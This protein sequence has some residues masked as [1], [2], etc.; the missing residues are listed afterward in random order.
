MVNLESTR[1][2]IMQ[3]EK[4]QKKFDAQLAEKHSLAEKNAADRDEA[5]AKARQAETKCLSLTRELDELHDSMEE[6]E[7]VRKQLQVH[8]DIVWYSSSSL[9]LQIFTHDSY[10][11]SCIS[12]FECS[13]ICLSLMLSAFLLGVKIWGC[14]CCYSQT[15]LIRVPWD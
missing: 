4:K 11:P 15:S 2:Q 9:A 12:D 5:E 6:S 8:S 10:I 3:L 1:G 7:R 14:L 13:C